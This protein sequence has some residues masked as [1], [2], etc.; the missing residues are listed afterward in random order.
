[1]LPSL[2]LLTETARASA[3]TFGTDSLNAPTALTATGG[4]SVSLNWAA[5]VD[6]YATG[7]RVY[8]GTT[9]GGPYSLI[10]E[11]TP[12]TNVSYSD[13]PPLGTRYYVLRAFIHSWESSN[14]NQV[15]CSSVLIV[16][17]C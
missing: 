7:H 6:A 16:F 3:N 15:T 9:S 14:S 8:R 10:A 17:V 11:V 5:T 2:A 4:T 12:R 1:V 13:S